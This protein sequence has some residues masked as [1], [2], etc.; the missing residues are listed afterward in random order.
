M[1]QLK[2]L[3]MSLA[4]IVMGLCVAACSNDDDPS[5]LSG[6]YGYC[7][8]DGYGACYYF[9]NKNTLKFYP[10]AHKGETYGSSGMLG[11][12]ERIGKSDWY[13]CDGESGQ[14]YTYIVEDN[15][16]II[17]MKGTILTVSG[18]TVTSDGGLTFTK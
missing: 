17:P 16:V 15:K 10:S 4:V 11:A 13:C 3:M 1:K 2:F 12:H 5:N 14:T 18:N 6:V 7:D 9:M 8:S